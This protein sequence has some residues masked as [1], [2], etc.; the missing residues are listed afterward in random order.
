VSRVVG[1]LVFVVAVVVAVVLLRNATM[2]VHTKMS[3]TSQLVVDASARWKASITE[4][5]NHAR[6]LTIACVSETSTRARLRDFRWRGDGRFRFWVKPSL[7][8]F[9]QRQLRGC[10]SDFRM[11]Q[12]L[13]DIHATRTVDPGPTTPREEG[14][15]PGSL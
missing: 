15:E 7:D 12:L 13:V 11:P 9:D 4:A 1:V 2:T 6:A 3:P 14:G 10:M 5:E 8:E